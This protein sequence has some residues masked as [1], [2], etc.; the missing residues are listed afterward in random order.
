MDAGHFP[1]GLATRIFSLRLLSAI[2]PLING[3]D[4]LERLRVPWGDCDDL[5]SSPF[6]IFFCF[7]FVAGRR[8]GFSL[9]SGCGRLRGITRYS[10]MTDAG[11]SGYPQ[12]V[13]YFVILATGLDCAMGRREVFTI[14]TMKLGGLMDDILQQFGLGWWRHSTGNWF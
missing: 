3:T 11:C 10:R 6:N 8:L 1:N 9:S 13:W 4:R 14:L 12:M 2:F 7:P 5:G